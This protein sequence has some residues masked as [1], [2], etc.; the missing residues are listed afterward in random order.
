MIIELLFGYSQFIRSLRRMAA[1]FKSVMGGN[2]R[3]GSTLQRKPRQFAFVFIVI[4]L[5][6][7]NIVYVVSIIYVIE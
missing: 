5:N 1:F 7:Y 4:M 6:V 2:G 3:A